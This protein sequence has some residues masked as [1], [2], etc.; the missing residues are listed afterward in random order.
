MKPLV[1]MFVLVLCLAPNFE[2]LNPYK[3]LGLSRYSSQKDVK[4][5]YKKLARE[6]HPD[7]HQNSPDL[8]SI[9]EKMRN[10]NEAYEM[11]KKKKTVDYDDYEN[12]ES[13]YEEYEEEEDSDYTQDISEKLVSIVLIIFITHYIQKYIKVLSKILYIG[14]YYTLI[15]MIFFYVSLQFGEKFLDHLFDDQEELMSSAFLS[16]ILFTCIFNYLNKYHKTHVDSLSEDP[17]Y[18]GLSLIRDVLIIL[19]I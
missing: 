6:F 12:E 18:D 11:L 19:R 3:T 17:E 16:S 1:L 4:T 9:K 7:K 8:E 5:A 15:V 2:C 10:I 13:E 14:T